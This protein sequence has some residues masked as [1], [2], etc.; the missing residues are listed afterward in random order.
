MPVLIPFPSLPQQ[1]AAPCWNCPLALESEHS[2]KHQG[3]MWDS[4]P[5][6]QELFT[7]FLSCPSFYHPWEAHKERGTHW[8]LLLAVTNRPLPGDRWE[9]PRGKWHWW[10]QV[11]KA[12]WTSTMPRRTWLR[13]QQILA[14]QHS[15]KKESEQLAD[16][17]VWLP[18][19]G[20]F[21]SRLADFATI[22]S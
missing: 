20:I 22:S 9:T 11:W 5:Q 1:Q 21:T 18:P 16:P 14:G 13:M 10:L 3:G 15:G 2:L 8:A 17:L 7:W 19:A 12:D 4:K 6:R